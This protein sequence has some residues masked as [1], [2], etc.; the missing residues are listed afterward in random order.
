M[1]SEEPQISIAKKYENLKLSDF[2]SDL[3]GFNYLS[4]QLCEATFQ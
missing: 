4:Y 1:A 2:F 3:R